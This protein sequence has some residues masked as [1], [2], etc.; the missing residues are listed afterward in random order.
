LVQARGLVSDRNGLATFDAGFHHATHFVSAALFVA[1]L[2]AQVDLYSRDVIAK[3][4]QGALYDATELS[5][6]CLASFNI[7]V[8]VDLD[9]HGTL[10]FCD[11]D[12]LN[13]GR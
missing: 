4:A 3:S 5:G 11:G 1:V 2:I 7:T 13:I 12:S 8:G 6:Q 9:L 10:L